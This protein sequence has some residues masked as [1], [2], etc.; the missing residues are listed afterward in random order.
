MFRDSLLLPFL[1]M[2]SFLSYLNVP[3]DQGGRLVYSWH[4]LSGLS[5]DITCYE[6]LG[7]V[8]KYLLEWIDDLTRRIHVL[9]AN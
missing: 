3:A 4:V 9:I 8:N 6:S 5:R 7:D 1:A 2:N